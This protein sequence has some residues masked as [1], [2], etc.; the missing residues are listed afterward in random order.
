MQTKTKLLWYSPKVLKNAN[1]RH[2]ISPNH[3]ATVAAESI[4]AGI[5]RKAT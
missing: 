3:Q 4:S 5:M 1:I 2:G